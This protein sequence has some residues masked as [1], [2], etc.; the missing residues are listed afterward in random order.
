MNEH[1]SIANENIQPA[2]PHHAANK[3]K[4]ISNLSSGKRKIDQKMIHLR[5]GN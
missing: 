5:N 3:K 2:T 1:T 4:N